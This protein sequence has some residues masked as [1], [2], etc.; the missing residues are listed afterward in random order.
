M[1]EKNCDFCGAAFS[2][3]KR[4]TWAYWEKARFCSRDCTGKYNSEQASK[5][6][7]PIDVLFHQKYEATDEGCWEW[8]GARDRDG[9]GIFTYAGKNYRAHKLALELDGRPVPNGKYACHKCNNPCCVRPSHLYPGTPTQNMEDAKAN[10][11][12]RMGEQVHFSK[13]TEKDVAAIRSSTLKDG[14]LANTFGVSR[15]CVTMIRNGK[16]WK[17]VS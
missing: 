14:L 11:T 10:G 8:G 1:S 12:I 4:N 17:H 2:R 15:S 13:L 6:R 5:K 3:D 16:T 9:Y 7:R